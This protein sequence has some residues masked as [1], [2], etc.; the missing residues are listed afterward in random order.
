MVT[1]VRYPS[2]L[3]RAYGAP[4]HAQI[5]STEFSVLCLWSVVGLTLTGLLFAMGFGGEI[6]QALTVAG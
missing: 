4:N 3:Q 1:T 6:A 2:G 5:A